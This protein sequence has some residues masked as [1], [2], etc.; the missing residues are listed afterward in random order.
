[1]DPEKKSLNGLF[2]LLNI[3]HP[4]KLFRR[5]AIGQKTENV[6][7]D[8]CVWNHHLS[9]GFSGSPKRW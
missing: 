5:L 8:V 4:K 9:M 3:R 7:W 2:S 1:M 6:W